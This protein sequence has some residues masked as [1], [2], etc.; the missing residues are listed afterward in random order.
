M[1]NPVTIIESC[2]GLNNAVSPQ[3]LKVGAGCELAAAVNVDIDARGE[4]TRRRGSSLSVEK[5]L[6]HSL[7][8]DAKDCLLVAR[9]GSQDALY[10]LEAD[11]TLTGLRSGLTN[12]LRMSYVQ[13]GNTIYYG[14]GKEKG[15]VHTG[16]TS[17]LWS[18]PSDYYG[19]KLYRSWIGPPLGHLLGKHGDRILVAAD[20]VLWYSERND[21][22][23]FDGSK[24]YRHLDSR[25]TMIQSTQDGVWIGTKGFTYYYA[26]I[27]IE[28]ATRRT[29]ANVGV[30]EGSG[31]AV[32]ATKLGMEVPGMIPLWVSDGICGGI[33][34][35]I[36]NFTEKRLSL[37][38]FTL[39]ASL[40]YGNK[41]IT[42][43]K[44]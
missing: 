39:A 36:I 28:T 26:G 14:N 34:G 40:I 16:G 2:S 30:K 23:R 41:F 31:K 9:N 42:I 25:I 35:Q 8:C 22:G 38:N 1:G 15:K 4:I 19:K 29:M 10:R 12:D 11:M 43:I 13:I 20:D 7:F 18:L 6:S 44:E 17:E 3:K 5:P 24:N 32:S 21:F 33:Q 37:P 27:D